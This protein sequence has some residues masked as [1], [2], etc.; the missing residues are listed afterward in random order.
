MIVSILFKLDK[1][2]LVTS[3]VHGMYEWKKQQL[4]LELASL[5]TQLQNTSTPIT[6]HNSKTSDSF[7][8]EQLRQHEQQM[9]Q[10]KVLMH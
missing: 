10:Q 6:S 2:Q 5:R 7:Q 3:I 8:E 1:S 9:I 4:A